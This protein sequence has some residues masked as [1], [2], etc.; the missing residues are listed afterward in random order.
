MRVLSRAAVLVALGAWFVSPRARAQSV[1]VG[2]LP[3]SMSAIPGASITVPVVADLTSSGGASLGSIA[4]RLT[5]KSGTLAYVSSSVGTLGSPTVNADSASGILRFA[6]ANAG[7]ATGMPVLIN[8]TFNVT[9]APA[10]TTIF[11]LSVTEIAAAGTFA[12]LK[13]IT[14]T[15]QASFCT[16]TGLWGDLNGDGQIMGDDALGILTHAVGRP[17][18]PPYSIANGDVDASGAADTRDALI[19][20]SAAVGIPVSQFRIGHINPGLCSLRSADSVQIQPRTATVAPGDSL[21]VTAV[22]KDSTGGLVQGVG[23]VWQS[24]DPTIMRPGAAGS[25]IAVAPGSTYALVFVQPG[26]RDSV[27]VVV[28]A[29]RHVW[30]VNPAVAAANLGIELGSQLYPFSSIDTAVA[31]AAANDTVHVAVADY[32]PVYIAKPIVMLGDS[33][34]GGFPRL[35]NAT[36]SALHVDTVSGAVTVSGFRLLNSLKGLSAK[37]V[38]TLSLGTLS[39]EGVHDI[40]IQAHGVDSLRM[41][42]VSVVGA[43]GTGISID[44]VRTA[45]LDSIRSDVIAPAASG[46]KPPLGFHAWNAGA[47]AG[48]DLLVRTAGVRIDSINVVALRRVRVQGSA[49]TGLQ[50]AANQVGVTGADISGATWATGGTPSLNDPTTFAVALSAGSALTFDSSIVH[51]NALFGL[52]AA[53]G[54]HDSL[55]GDSVV[56][57][58]GIASSNYSSSYFTG[59]SN[60][61]IA[62]TVFQGGGPALVYFYASGASMTL[63]TTVFDGAPL[64]AY[65]PAQFAMHGGAV[66]NGRDYAVQVYAGSVAAFDSVE[67]TGT[68][69]TSSCC[70]LAPGAIYVSGVDSTNVTGLWAHDNQGGALSV[71]SGRVLRVLGGSFQHNGFGSSSYRRA[72]IAAER[73]R[74][75]LVYGVSL[76]DAAD[77]AIRFDAPGGSRSVVDSSFLEGSYTLVGAYGT[78]SSYHDTVTVSRSWLTGYQGTSGYGVDGARLGRLV[79][80]R[81]FLDSLY[82][83][84]INADTS[85]GATVSLNQIR[86]SGNVGIY[87]T[88]GPILADSNTLAGCVSTGAAIHLFGASASVVGNGFTGCGPFVIASSLTPT[89]V[90]VRGNSVAL[91]TI[92]AVSGF[93]IDLSQRLG[94][95]HVAG[96]TIVGG[97]TGGIRIDGSGYGVDSARLDS[98]VVRLARGIGIVIGQQVG[99]PDSLIYNVIAD[100]AA[101]GLQST[102]IISAAYNTV[103]RNAGMGG[104]TDF[105][106][107]PSS[108]RLGN[109][110]GNRP[111]GLYGAGTYVAADSNWWNDPLGPTCSSGCS[112]VTG[113]SVV[114]VGTNWFP[115]TSTGPVVGAPAIPAPPTVS[116]VRPAIAAA[117]AVPRTPMAPAGVRTGFRAARVAAPF[118][119]PQAI[120]RPGPSGSPGAGGRQ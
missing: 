61:E 116:V 16:S 17:L 33:T 21:P 4:A 35:T 55:R 5:W 56:R 28:T 53:G 87:A 11:G 95:V 71:W 66:R 18:S 26:V 115:F 73:I 81:N 23:L 37:L 9:G 120:V 31:R 99:A 40:G 2:P 84:G 110:V 107:G 72:T 3:S 48:T 111:R 91:D 117:R 114:G 96:N 24:K 49:G 76:R 22:V 63:D 51:D 39:I 77:N 19:V 62:R 75:A 36:G 69:L 98:N 10:D 41:L 50:V 32:G 20:L 92:T 1:V 29:T 102:S 112:G 89:P 109:I 70:G 45:V 30:Y 65:H 54:A 78:D 34:G 85:G 97:T 42:R 38:Q 119:P 57:N 80:V 101:G 83:V 7:G 46:G 68:Q 44:S 59:F 94:F 106:G 58:A 79:A 8:V 74:D 13:R 67:V 12:D 105:T 93:A 103:V 113:D 15:T 100:N 52:W 86:A 118:T 43:V 14:V 108:F 64:Y 90:E 47:L 88:N 6:L 25:L 27:P 104:V 82:T 60:L